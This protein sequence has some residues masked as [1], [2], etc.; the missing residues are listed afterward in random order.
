M[1]TSAHRAPNGH[2]DQTT[3]DSDSTA[4]TAEIVEAHLELVRPFSEWLDE[5]IAADRDLGGIVSRVKQ[6]LADFEAWILSIKTC[7]YE[8]ASHHAVGS[9]AVE[10]HLKGP[11]TVVVKGP[12]PGA[13]VEIHA[14]D[15]EEAAWI[16]GDEFLGYMSTQC[17]DFFNM[18]EL[19]LRLLQTQARIEQEKLE[20][21]QPP[22]AIVQSRIR[23]LKRYN[24][25]KDVGQQLIGLVAENRGVPVGKVYEEG[26]FGVTGDD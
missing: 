7:S 11:R 14:D 25:V 24:D 4:Q 10:A 16:L 8:V 13:T 9:W 18:E 12:A 3:A 20:L 15:E 21:S 22:E 2:N 5:T 23:L 19:L 1:E 17:Q 6:R 26:E